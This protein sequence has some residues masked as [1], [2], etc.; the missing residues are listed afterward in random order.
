M[1]GIHPFNQIL[2]FGNT[3]LANDLETLTAYKFKENSIVE[4]AFK[5]NSNLIPSSICD[6]FYYKD[7]TLVNEQT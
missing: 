5:L 1:T 3:V 2:K 6:K 7:V 4:L